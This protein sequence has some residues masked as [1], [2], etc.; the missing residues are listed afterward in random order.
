[1]A[2]LRCGTNFEKKFIMKYLFLALLTTIVAATMAQPKQGGVIKI[3]H[4]A[5]EIINDIAY[6]K[7]IPFTGISLTLWENKHVNEEIPWKDGQKEGVYKEFTDE[8]LLITTITWQA[9][10]KKWTL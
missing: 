8:N 6:Y 5:L 2:K 7:N 10:Q 4:E 1:M 3:R 9:G